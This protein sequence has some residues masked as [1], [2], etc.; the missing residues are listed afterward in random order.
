MTSAELR[1]LDGL[2]TSGDTE[3][4][5]VESPQSQPAIQLIANLVV[6]RPTGEVLFVPG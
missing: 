6:L 1:W 2:Q 5:L 4:S 3:V